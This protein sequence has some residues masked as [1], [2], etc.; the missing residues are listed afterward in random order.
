MPS[1]Q[2]KSFPEAHGPSAL[3]GGWDTATVLAVLGPFSIEVSIGP[4]GKEVVAVATHVPMPLPGQTVLLARPAEAPA[5]VVAAYGA[6]PSAVPVPAAPPLF[7]FDA[8]SGV[9][10]IHAHCIKLEG[11][12]SIEL[13]CADA[14]L[15]LN[16]HG[17]LLSQAQTITQA[18]IG[19]HR[20]EGASVDI[21]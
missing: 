18:A 16:A 7:D 12:G 1:A 9:L 14:M 2:T 21:N 3:P 5:L 4:A 20:I 13:H 6:L 11:V 17:E 19:S 8:Q 15:R 10:T